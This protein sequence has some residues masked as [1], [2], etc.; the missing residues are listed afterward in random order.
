[1]GGGI[2]VG[3]VASMFGGS[4]VAVI[5]Y[6]T[7]RTKI[8]AEARKIDAETE[9]IRVDTRR[10]L[11]EMGIYRVIDSAHAVDDLPSG[12]QRYEEDVSPGSYI[13]GLDESVAHS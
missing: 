7:N 4:A 1:M 11:Q 6:V 5:T 9:Q 2:A 3:L 8:D 10:T 13:L 12:W